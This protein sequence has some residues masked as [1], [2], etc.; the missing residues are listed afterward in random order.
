MFFMLRERGSN[1]KI[2]QV[3]RTERGRLACFS[4][5]LKFTFS[6]QYLLFSRPQFRAR[7]R[8]SS[9]VLYSELEVTPS[10][11]SVLRGHLPGHPI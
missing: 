3:A 11:W 4:W 10:F 5:K 8:F 6:F 1:G 2:S 7:V 9:L